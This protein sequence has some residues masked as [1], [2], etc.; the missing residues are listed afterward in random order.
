MDI[1]ITGRNMGITDRFRAYATE[2]SEKIAH[3][4]DRALALEIK[5]SRHSE[6]KGA[7]GGD[8]VE[9]TLIGKGPVV[10]AEAS[11]ADKYA[12]FDVALGRLLERVRRAKDRKKVHRGQ[13]RPTS[14][15]DAAADDFSVVAIQPADAEVL[16][17][18]STGVIPVQEEPAPEPVAA[19]EDDAEEPYCPVVIR[20]KVFPSVSM[21]V[22]D[23]VDYM[24]LVGHD[25][26]LFID[27]DTD[28][29]SVVYRRK[30]WDYGVIGLG[31]EADAQPEAA[32]V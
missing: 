5:A 24:E 23:A 30:G 25:F 6:G 27:A 13:H 12:A 8:R 28:R 31:D 2:K 15:R 4:A 32:A 11:G 7:A 29:P 9:L 20:K 3:L 22:D 26:Y 17:R 14:L 19:D 21:S 10:R 16:E 18:L 1:D